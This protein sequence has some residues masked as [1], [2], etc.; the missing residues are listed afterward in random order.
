[1]NQTILDR[2]KALGGDISQVKGKSLAEDLMSITFDT[3]LYPKPEDT[4]WADEEDQEPIYG[5]GEYIDEHQEL[6]QTDRQAF[7]HKMIAHYYVHTEEGRGQV[8]WTVTPFTPYK[9]GTD[10]YEEWNTDFMDEDFVNLSEMEK[11]VGTKY[12]SMIQLF[13]SYGFPDHYYI[14]ID[15]PNQENP[16]LFGTDHEVFFSEVTN[17]GSLEAFMNTFM[18][19]QELISIVDKALNKQ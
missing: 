6:I 15:D 5:L 12:P 7:M 14:C 8:F 4:P 16:T 18:T 9:E 10:D 3:V 2:I 19:P 13:Y 11:V 17:E 1:M